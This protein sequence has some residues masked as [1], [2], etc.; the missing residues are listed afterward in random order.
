MR[1]AARGNGIESTSAGYLLC[2]LD[3]MVPGTNLSLDK[4]VQGTNL[5]GRDDG[6]AHAAGGLASG[7]R[8]RQASIGRASTAG[9]HR[10]PLPIASDKSVLEVFFAW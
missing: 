7:A 1:A 9:Q 4:M 2:P 3:K 8:R 6:A 5:A 10:T